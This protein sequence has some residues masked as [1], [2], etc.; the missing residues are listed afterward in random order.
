MSIKKNEYKR[1]N[2]FKAENFMKDYKEI[3]LRVLDIILI[4]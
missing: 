3:G 2:C 4:Q 1:K